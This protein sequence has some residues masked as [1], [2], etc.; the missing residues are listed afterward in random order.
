MEK[1]SLD[2]CKIVRLSHPA[3]LAGFTCD[4]DD[5]DDFFA[6]EAH[7]YARQLLGKT[8]FFVTDEQQPEVVGA[9]TVS[10]D[11]IKASLISKSLRNRLQRK[12]PNT[13]RTRSYPAV[14]IGR[15]GVSRN[16]RGHDIGSQ[17]LDY[18]KYWFSNDANKSGCRYV[19][20][21]AYNKP[22]VLNFYVKNEFKY[23]YRDEAEERETFFIDEDMPLKSRLMYFDLINIYS[24][25]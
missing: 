20:V 21:D 15:L 2:N 9:F 4:D 14:L 7:L 25:E 1:F 12:I 22:E 24:P 3:D 10:N 19:V 23:L 11:S 5:L 13:K 16:R 6:N 18:I 17:I 8:Y